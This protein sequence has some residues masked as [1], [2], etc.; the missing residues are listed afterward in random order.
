[1]KGSLGKRVV[2]HEALVADWSSFARCGHI[3]SAARRELLIYFKVTM[4][5]A[6]GFWLTCVVSQS[7]TNH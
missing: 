5:F 2:G 6:L 1:M 4:Q 7:I 3:M